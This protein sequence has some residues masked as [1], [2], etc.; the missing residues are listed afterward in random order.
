VLASFRASGLAVSLVF[1][2]QQQVSAK[3]LAMAILRLLPAVNGVKGAHRADG[4]EHCA[5][6]GPR[7]CPTLG[8][9]AAALDL[10][11]MGW[12]VT[13]SVRKL[14]LG[15]APRDL[16]AAVDS[17]WLTGAEAAALIE[18]LGTLDLAGDQ[19]D[20]AGTCLPLLAGV[21]IAVVD[22]YRATIADL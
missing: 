6:A 18:I 1:M 15:M 17:R 4:C 3:R 9:A 5:G 16:G 20:D 22:N 14:P 21:G 12:W 13:R 2:A 19:V 11:I 8:L 10:I 7:G